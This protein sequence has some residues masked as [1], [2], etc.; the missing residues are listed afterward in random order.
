MSVLSGC[1]TTW[2]LNSTDRVCIWQCRFPLLFPCQCQ[3]PCPWLNSW[4]CPCSVSMIVTVSVS[5]SMSGPCPWVSN[6]V[7]VWFRVLAHVSETVTVSISVRACGHV[8]IM[9]PCRSP[10]PRSCSW[11][12]PL[13]CPFSWSFE[14]RPVSVSVSVAGVG[15]V[16]IYLNVSLSAWPRVRSSWLHV[17]MHDYVS[18]RVYVSVR[19]RFCDH[20]SVRSHA[21]I[22]C[23]IRVLCRFWWSRVVHGSD[24]PAGRVGSGHDFAGFGRVGWALQVFFLIIFSYWIDMNLRVL[25]SNWL[26]FYT[27]FNLYNNE[28]NN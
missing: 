3:W 13:P 7:R 20:V 25:D 23:H 21:R 9:W 28:L 18:V 5:V 6:R 27:I 15:G 10:W 19:F 17:S 14:S 4:P 22:Q 11:P 16:T 12:Y 1:D 8:S 24:G 26:F 2:V